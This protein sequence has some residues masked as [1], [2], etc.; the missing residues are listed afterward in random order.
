[1]SGP[2]RARTARGRASA[3]DAVKNRA[4]WKRPRTQVVSEGAFSCA[5]VRGRAGER[6]RPAS[7]SFFSAVRL[8][9][10]GA[11]REM[12]AEAGLEARMGI[13]PGGCLSASEDGDRGLRIR[14][15]LRG[16]VGVGGAWTP[17]RRGRGRAVV[18]GC[19]IG[20]SSG[21]AAIVCREERG[22]RD[23]SRGCDSGCKGQSSAEP[24]I[25]SARIPGMP[26]SAPCAGAGPFRA[27]WR[28][29]ERMACARVLLPTA[30]KRG[31][32]HGAPVRS[33]RTA[34]EAGISPACLRRLGGREGVDR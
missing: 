21:R 14:M 28:R 3:P 33:S 4:E 2:A 20:C 7:A 1:M 12:R 23:L 26:A 32:P 13:Q 27:G 5:C 25:P 29:R 15:W 11:G 10:G 17:L 22:C 24:L 18:R 9:R 6:L 8:G 19:P 30:T 34:G 31:E 16:M